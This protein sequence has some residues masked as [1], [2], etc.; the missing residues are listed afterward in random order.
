MRTTRNQSGV[1]AVEMA[2]LLPI[3]LLLAFGL[4]ELGRAVYQYNALT[5]AVRDGARHL[6]QF[7]P[8]DAVSI[9]EA[10]RLVLCATPNTTDSA[11]ANNPLVPGMSLGYIRVY[12]R[13]TDP[14][15]NL[16]ET[17][18]GTVN[19]VRVEVSGFP[20]RSVVPAIIPSVTFA[21]IN[22]TMVQVL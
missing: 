12:D 18:R 9:A 22:A 15:Y 19:L 6:S 5:K 3:L 17:G 13:T 11:C 8:G 7:A 1:A 20:F 2:L 14:G 21:P 16:Q 4:T 10:K